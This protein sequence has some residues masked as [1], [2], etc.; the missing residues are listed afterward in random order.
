[1]YDDSSI[2]D[3][4][5]LSTDCSI[6]SILG[7]KG[8]LRLRPHTASHKAHVVLRRVEN[9]DF[10][11]SD[12]EENNVVYFSLFANKLINIKPG[13]ELLLTVD[14]PDGRFKDQVVRLE[15]TLRGPEDE[16]KTQVEEEPQVIEEE[17]DTV[18][19]ATIPPKM[20]RQWTRKADE[21]SPVI[22]KPP[23]SYTSVGVQA[24]QP[25]YVSSS[26]QACPT[27][28]SASV[29][30]QPSTI[31]TSVHAY[32][33]GI[34]AAVQVDPPPPPSYTSL[35]VQTDPDL[36]PTEDHV[37]ERSSS[38]MELESPDLPSVGLPWVPIKLEVI[39]V[40]PKDTRI[41][42]P[43]IYIKQELDEVVE[44]IPPQ[45]DLI[46]R[47]CIQDARIKKE[48]QDEV[49][50]LI[51]PQS[52]LICGARIQDARIKEQDEV[53][54]IIPPPR[55]LTRRARVQDMFDLENT[56][57]P[58]EALVIPHIPPR[59]VPRPVLHNPFVSA[60]FVTDFVSTVVSSVRDP[61]PRVKMEEPTVANIPTFPPNIPLPSVPP[62]VPVMRSGSSPAPSTSSVPSWKLRQRV[63]KKAR[64]AKKRR[65]AALANDSNSP[66]PSTLME[67][68]VP[69][70]ESCAADTVN[71]NLIFAENSIDIPD[72]SLLSQTAGS[73]IP[74]EPLPPPPPLP[75]SRPPVPNAVASSSK[76]VI[77]PSPVIKPLSVRAKEKAPAVVVDAAST[78]TD[79]GYSSLSWTASAIGFATCVFFSNCL[80]ISS[81]LFCLSSL[82]SPKLIKRS[83]GLTTQNPPR[84]LQTP[85][86]LRTFPLG[87]P[88]TD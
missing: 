57:E 40:D 6:A 23:V 41:V 83:L 37:E 46:R 16:D 18:P 50:E 14:A 11:I 58:P 30:A 76:V 15:G 82:P 28:N 74:P 1:M 88:P 86:S 84:H 24:E 9:P 8:N 56:P 10:S 85:R 52:D 44:P 19:Q 33:C 47:A 64:R 7:I 71:T 25:I 20:R 69:N 39:D 63:G 81:Q 13:K 77:P 26:V 68:S 49:V 51:P 62:A 31:S 35:D 75:R 3:T 2:T 48:E 45:S 42:L 29:Q 36:D 59:A 66:Q 55:D 67:P 17:E 5:S 12:G 87:R 78:Q 72:D 53:V 27:Q 22:F 54:E 79:G 32:P 61:P 73:V 60:G 65:A 70:E 38:P 80:R 4:E 34:S 43:P 21:V